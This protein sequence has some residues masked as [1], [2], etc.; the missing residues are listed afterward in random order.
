[1]TTTLDVSQDNFY[2]MEAFYAGSVEVLVGADNR[3][4]YRRTGTRRTMVTAIKCV[5]ASEFCFE[6]NIIKFFGSL[7]TAYRTEVERHYRR[8]PTNAN[9]EHF[10]EIY[11]FLFNPSRVTRGIGKPDASQATSTPFEAG[12]QHGAIQT[13]V[14][15]VAPVTPVPSED[16]MNLFRLMQENCHSD[17]I[18]LIRITLVF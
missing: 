10:T 15:P 7:K 1:M 2:N 5:C 3:R 16:V 14:T 18:P 17:D 9:K 11:L 6:N 12:T 13:P 8:G 4:D